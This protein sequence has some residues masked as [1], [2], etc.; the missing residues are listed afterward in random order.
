M[1][2]IR[3]ISGRSNTLLADNIA[4]KLGIKSTECCLKD[5][6]NSEIKVEIQESIRGKDLFIIQSGSSNNDHSIN[7]YIVELLLLLN[8]CKLSGA[9]SISVIVPYFPYSRSDKKDAPRVPIAASWFTSALEDGGANRIISMDLHAG[10]IQGFA[11]CIPFDNLYAINI[12]IKELQNRFFKD[13]TNEQINEKYI[14]VSPDCGGIKRCDAYSKILKMNYVIMHKQRDYSKESCVLNSMLIGESKQVAGKTAII[15]DD[16]GDTLGTMCAASNELKKHRVSQVII[17]VSHGILSG[18]A[19]DNLKECD[20][21]KNVIVTNTLPQEENM[22][23]SDKIIVADTAELFATVINN[24]Q[25]GISISN[26][27]H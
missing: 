1:D 2:K 4:T 22:K 15:I 17:A 12:I 5:F 8:A 16:I 9:N 11:H 7:D 3:I 10:Q 18:K 6:S 24:V 19:F 23:K 27:F 21:I 25:Q 20:I 14:L 13:M 26:L